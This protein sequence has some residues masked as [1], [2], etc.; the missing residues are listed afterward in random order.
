IEPAGKVIT[1]PTTEPSSD[2]RLMSPAN[3]S[4][5]SIDSGKVGRLKQLWE[6]KVAPHDAAL[7][8]AAQAQYETIAA[9]RREQQRLI[10]ESDRI[11]RT[12][13]ELEKRYQEMT[14]PRP[15]PSGSEPNGK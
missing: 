15:E 5:V 9:L 13:D 11:Q 12:I 14:T 4:E 3:L 8:E 2:A 1:P 7:R 6:Q 10:D